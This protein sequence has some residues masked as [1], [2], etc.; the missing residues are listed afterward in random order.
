MNQ[1]YGGYAAMLSFGHYVDCREGWQS[2]RFSNGSCDMANAVL[3]RVGALEYVVEP[4]NVSAPRPND[5]LA[6]RQLG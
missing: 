6:S 2:L 4:R 3:L 5:E 1:T